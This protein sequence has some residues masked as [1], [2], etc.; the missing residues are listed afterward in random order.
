MCGGRRGALAT[1]GGGVGWGYQGLLVSSWENSSVWRTEGALATSGG[2]VGWGYQGSLV[3]SW[4][5][6]SSGMSARACSSTS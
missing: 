6:S 2:V 3:S 1:S 5:N 4:E